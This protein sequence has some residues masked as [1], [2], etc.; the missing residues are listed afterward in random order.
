M[1]DEGG[2]DQGVIG[3][4]C[5]LRDKDELIFGGDCTS[6]RIFEHDFGARNEFVFAMS[7]HDCS[8]RLYSTSPNVGCLSAQRDMRGDRRYMVIYMYIYHYY[9]CTTILQPDVGRG[10]PKNLEYLSVQIAS[11]SQGHPGLSDRRP[12]GSSF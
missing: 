1:S 12:I 4:R 6:S 5:R 10:C 11:S 3:I 9:S 8:V 7:S 2:T